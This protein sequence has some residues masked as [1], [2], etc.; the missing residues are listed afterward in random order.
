MDSK[1]II[2]SIE[3]LSE[4]HNIFLWEYI[5]KQEESLIRTYSNNNSEN[6]LEVLFSTL[7]DHQYPE[8]L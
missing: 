6:T 7:K 3:D 4:K 1:S 8:V 2:S 5:K